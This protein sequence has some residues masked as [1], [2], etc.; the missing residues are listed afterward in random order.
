MFVS[1]WNQRAK[2]FEGAYEYIG[3]IYIPD[4]DSTKA[5]LLNRTTGMFLTVY[6]YEIK[7][8]RD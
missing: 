2:E 1:K 7:F 8:L 5:I 3:A 4:V 6:L